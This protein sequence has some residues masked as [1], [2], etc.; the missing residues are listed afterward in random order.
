M[1]QAVTLRS[2][3]A[4]TTIR[5]QVNPC[6]MCDGQSVIQI[7]FYPSTSV[8]AWETSKCSFEKRGALSEKLL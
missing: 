1:I 6:E 2:L 3:T 4:E 8:F 7:D 5:S